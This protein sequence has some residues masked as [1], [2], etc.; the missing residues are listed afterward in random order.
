MKQPKPWASMQHCERA[1]ELK[2]AEGVSRQRECQGE[3]GEDGANI[4]GEGGGVDEAGN[5]GGGGRSHV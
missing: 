3:G 1:H 5:G 4:S 2:C